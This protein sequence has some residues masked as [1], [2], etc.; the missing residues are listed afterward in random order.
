MSS[1][2]QFDSF[3][4]SNHREALKNK[5]YIYLYIS[6]F[7]FFLFL[8]YFAYNTFIPTMTLIPHMLL[9]QDES[10]DRWLEDDLQSIHPKNKPCSLQNIVLKENKTPSLKSLVEF[11]PNDSMPVT[12]VYSILNS[13]R[14]NEQRVKD[15]A[16][17][18]RNPACT[19]ELKR[20]RNTDA[21][22]R[23]RQRKANKMAFLETQVSMLKKDNNRLRLKVAVLES[24]VSY[25]AEKEQMS[26]QRVLELE[27]QLA[28]AHQ[29]LVN[30]A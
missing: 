18:R 14:H 20:Q 17:L 12:H 28:N 21:A 26:M 29:Q 25:A 30:R 8:Y 11:T 22:R 4:V 13:I 6:F 1:L 10:L 3:D 15:K 16:F 24:E 7:L 27:A 2:L 5:L 9:D 19:L 23:S